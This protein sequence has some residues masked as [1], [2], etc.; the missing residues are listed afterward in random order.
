MLTIPN[1]PHPLLDNPSDPSP[2]L[3][4]RLLDRNS[5][6]L[7]DPS[8]PDGH[9]HT[10][11]SHVR[12]G[13]LSPPPQQILKELLHCTIALVQDQYGNYVVQHA[14]EHGRPQDKHEI[15]KHLRGKI[16]QL[17][18]HKFAS[19]LE[20]MMK[21]QYANCVVQKIIDVCDARAM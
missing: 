16:V 13:S 8:D 1:P 19:A 3:E 20:T 4:G 14:L 2:T 9:P 21:D 11:R 17:S 6:P 15:V 18:Q 5:H 7:M 12:R 10:R